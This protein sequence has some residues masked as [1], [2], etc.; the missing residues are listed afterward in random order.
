MKGYLGYPLCGPN[1]ETRHS[2]RLKKM[3]TLDIDATLG[4]RTDIGGI[5]LILMDN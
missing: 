4:G 3:F 1:V 5:L 2:S